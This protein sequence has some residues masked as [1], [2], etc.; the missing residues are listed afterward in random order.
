MDRG[1]RW[2][3]TSISKERDVDPILGRSRDPEG[4]ELHSLRS[5]FI[6]PFP[7]ETLRALSSSQRVD[8]LEDELAGPRFLLLLS[9][10]EPRSTHRGWIPRRRNRVRRVVVG[11]RKEERR[12][13]R[14]DVDEQRFR[15][16]KLLAMV[17]GLKDREGRELLVESRRRQTR[18][19]LSLSS[20]CRA[21]EK[22]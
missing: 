21:K 20:G 11:C 5:L 13:C 12:I 16:A 19:S 3:L 6:I 1:K 17:R 18:W 14:V 4:E 8:L 22:S 7:H 10:L 9:I 15:G 2:R